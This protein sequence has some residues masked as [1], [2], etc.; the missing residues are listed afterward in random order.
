MKKNFY[1]REL[2]KLNSNGL[3]RYYCITSYSEFIH[4]SIELNFRDVIALN[5]IPK[6][7]N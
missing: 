1:G 7:Y 3:K 6:N 4:F 2:Q 5:Q